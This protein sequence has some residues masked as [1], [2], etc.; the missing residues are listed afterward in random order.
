MIEQI[1]PS[2]VCYATTRA[3]W[4][5]VGVLRLAVEPEGAGIGGLLSTSGAE[6]G[7]WKSSQSLLSAACSFEHMVEQVA[8]S[9]VANFAVGAIG[10]FSICSMKIAMNVHLLEGFECHTT[11]GKGT[12][13]WSLH[14]LWGRLNHRSFAGLGGE[15]LQR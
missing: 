7:P 8:P 11:V 4:S 13:I 2:V 10:L 12:E 1:A 9:V 15:H 14:L 3:G 5:C 6:E